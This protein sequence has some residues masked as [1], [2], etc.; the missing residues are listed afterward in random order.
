MRNRWL[1]RRDSTNCRVHPTVA[2]SIIPSIF[3]SVSP[4]ASL[5]SPLRLTPAD[6]LNLFSEATVLFASE[7]KHRCGA[8]AACARMGGLTDRA[9]ASVPRCEDP[10]NG[11]ECWGF[12]FLRAHYL[13]FCP[14]L[15]HVARFSLRSSRVSLGVRFKPN[16]ATHAGARMVVV[17]VK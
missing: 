8:R 7:R 3:P 5:T 16:H 2:A 15:L 4:I 17:R 14:A 9:R 1:F 13:T 6:D 12:E 11:S 10:D